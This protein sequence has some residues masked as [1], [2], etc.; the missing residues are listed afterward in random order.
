PESLFDYNFEDF[1]V[2]DYQHHDPIKAPVA[3]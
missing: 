2:Q 3:V 1:E